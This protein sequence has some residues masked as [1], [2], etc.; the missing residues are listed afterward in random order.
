MEDVVEEVV[1][2]QNPIKLDKYAINYYTDVETS[3]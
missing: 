3:N 1:K 2:S